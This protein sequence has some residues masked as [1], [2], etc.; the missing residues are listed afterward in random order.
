MR[1]FIT[2]RVRPMVD[3]DLALHTLLVDAF[4]NTAVRVD[5]VFPGADRLPAL[6]VGRAG[7]TQD[8]PAGG[9]DRPRIDLDAYAL[10]RQ[11]S[12]VLLGDA[13]AF[14]Y[15]CEGMSVL[16]RDGTRFVFATVDA[17]SGL[18]TGQDEDTA[19]FRATSSVVL[20][21][22]QLAPRLADEETRIGGTL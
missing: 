10:R 13:L 6:V 21:I 2:T 3:V 9:V 19:A 5:S 16:M 14:L 4:A 12:I 20:T 8:F 22:H 1:R 15:G 18:I 11:A 7:G 17:E